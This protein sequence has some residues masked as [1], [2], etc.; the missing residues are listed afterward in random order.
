VVFSVRMRRSLGT[1]PHFVPPGPNAGSTLGR[2]E[3]LRRQSR[4]HRMPTL[5]HCWSARKWA[6]VAGRETTDCHPARSLAHAKGAPTKGTP[7]CGTACCRPSTPAGRWPR[8]SVREHRASC[9]F[10]IETG[11]DLPSAVNRPHRSRRFSGLVARA[12]SVGQIAHN[13]RGQERIRRSA[14]HSPP[15]IA[16][17]TPD[18]KRGTAMGPHA[19][20]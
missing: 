17:K 6:H 15:A 5:L 18:Y 11:P 3:V 20:D 10:M 2:T 8:S 1:P 16:G 7:R 12:D 13:P 9:K 14:A 19:D 4:C